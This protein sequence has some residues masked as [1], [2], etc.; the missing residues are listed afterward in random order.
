VSKKSLHRP[1]TKGKYRAK[2]F[3]LSDEVF[4]DA[5]VGAGKP[6]DLLGK[7]KW[8]QLMVLPTDVLLKTTEHLGPMIQDMQRQS[9]AWMDATPLD[10]T[11]WPFFHDAYLDVLEEF[12]AAPFIAAHGWYRQATAALR[13]ALEVM[14]HA[15]R[16]AVANDKAGF[17]SWRDNTK[18][19]PRFGNS[20]DIIGQ[21]P[22]GRSLDLTL[23]GQGLFGN[24]PDGVLR[25]LYSDVCRYAHSQPGFSNGDIWQ[26]NGPV[27]I[28]RAFTQFWLDYCDTS[29]ACFALLKLAYP[30]TKGHEMFKD[31]ADNVG[32]SWHGLAPATV[33]ALKLEKR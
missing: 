5:G 33:K 28:P 31:I 16:Y 13:N 2:R 1:V 20:I 18:D 11:A 25:A 30:S 12:D 29:L 7:K 4:L 26:S 32:Q 21:K 10:P 17:T 15:C 3:Y 9:T 27:F 14:A 24:K 8:D 23:G 19:P 6:I 22:V